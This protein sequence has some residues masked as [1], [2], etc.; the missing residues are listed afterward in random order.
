MEKRYIMLWNGGAYHGTGGR[1]VFTLAEL[2]TEFRERMCFDAAQ[3]RNS[4][5]IDDE[6]RLST[7]EELFED[8]EEAGNL[9]TAHYIWERDLCERGDDH[10]VA[11][12]V[13]VLQ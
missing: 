11:S 12:L 9:A 6:H 1:N 4:D 7:L 13:E 2:A 8:L 5:D 3:V 10:V